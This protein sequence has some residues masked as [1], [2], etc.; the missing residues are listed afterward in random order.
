MGTGSCES[1][2]KFLSN[3]VCGSQNLFFTIDITKT[4]LFQIH[5]KVLTQ[6]NRIQP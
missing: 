5:L 2:K 6:Q 1:L 3:I 4:L